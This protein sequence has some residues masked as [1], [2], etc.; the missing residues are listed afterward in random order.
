MKKS[1]ITLASFMLASC[2]APYA[3]PNDEPTF[4]PPYEMT[5]AVRTGAENAVKNS[6]KDPDSAH[7]GGMLAFKAGDGS[8]WV[9]GYVNAKNSFGG[10]VGMQ[11]FFTMLTPIGDGSQLYGPSALISRADRYGPTVFYQVKP[12][13]DPKYRGNYL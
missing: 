11:P 2:A 12:I 1:V 10:Y 3:A 4:L 5:D 9:C 13:C 7:F 8:I 6:L